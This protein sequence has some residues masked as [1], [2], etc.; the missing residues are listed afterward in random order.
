LKISS[1]GN[2]K[3]SSEVFFLKDICDI[4]TGISSLN[5]GKEGDPKYSLIQLKDVNDDGFIEK[6]LGEVFISKLPLSQVLRKNE[7]LLKA[8]S[9]NNTAAIIDKDGPYIATSHFLILSVI[10]KKITPSYLWWY[11][12]QR[13]AQRYFNK[14]ASGGM[15]PII[16][17][18]DLDDLEV[19]VPPESKQ[20]KIVEA[21]KLWIREKD[22]LKE[23]IELKEK[24]I[25][26]YL[27]ES[28]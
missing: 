7:I 5:E 28:I 10:N 13:I 16:K 6:D 22:L 14:M 2:I 21:Y 9:S 19:I 26:E 11:L 4:R 15:M 27:L 23:K 3:D 17:K 8:K 25:K 12:N 20:E 18:G 1:V 24:Y